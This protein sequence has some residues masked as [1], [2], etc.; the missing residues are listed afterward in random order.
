MEPAQGKHIVTI[1]ELEEKITRQCERR[2]QIQT[3]SDT[4][5]PKTARLEQMIVDNTVAMEVNFTTI[6]GWNES[7]ILAGEE[8]QDMPMVF[9]FM[10]LDLAAHFARGVLDLEQRH[11]K[12]IFNRNDH[13]LMFGFVA[14]RLGDENIFVLWHRNTNID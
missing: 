6:G 3:R 12:C 10:R 2:G 11:S 9:L 1:T 5:L 8:F 4:H 7:T 14:M 13:V